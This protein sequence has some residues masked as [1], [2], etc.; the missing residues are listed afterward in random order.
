[1][2]SQ[3]N[4][5]GQ[6]ELVGGLIE[7]AVKI[8]ILALV[9]VW[10]YN[11]V[12][13]FIPIVLWG[14]ILAIALYPVVAL[15]A[16]K[17]KRSEKQ[18]SILVSI[19]LLAVI[20]VPM[21]YIGDSILEGSGDLVE[22]YQKGELQVP[23]PPA[24][25]AEWPFVG[26]K[27]YSVWQQFADNAAQA[28]QKFKPQIKEFGQWLLAA[29]ANVG[30]TTL[31]FIGSILIAGFFMTTA[32][33]SKAFFI[34]TLKRIKGQQGEYMVGLSIGTI[35]SVAQGVIGIAFIQALLAAPALL[36]MDVPLAGLWV[37]AILVLAIVQLPGIIVVG[38]IIFYVFSVADPTAATI[39]AVYMFIVGFSD[40]I[41]KPILLGRG[42]DVPMLVILLGA[43]GGMILSGIIGLFTG[44]V[45]LAL[46][47]TL[48][49]AWVNNNLEEEAR[50]L[51]GTT[52]KS[53]D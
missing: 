24:K 10:C 43:I 28:A 40:G 42:L 47:Y 15:L 52:E 51:A 48:F 5:N 30:M 22:L 46:G 21:V 3:N 9:I 19:A 14:G 34:K 18:A 26:D 20:V 41:L 38:P 27:I 25:V 31:F 49:S 39:F 6:D 50:A 29:G 37:V 13:P 17:L 4:E 33:S 2:E 7:A 16:K 1:M 23:Q 53:A 12:K 35:R 44:A 45:V 8:G 32:Q 11:I 36:I